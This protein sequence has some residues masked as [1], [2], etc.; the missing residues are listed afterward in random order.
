MTEEFTFTGKGVPALK[1][2][3]ETTEKEDIKQEP[4]QKFVVMADT[5]VQVQSG[6]ADT[7]ATQAVVSDESLWTPVVEELNA[8]GENNG[9]AERS[10][11]IIFLLGFGG[12][13]LALLTPCVWPMI[14][15]T[16]SFFLKRTRIV[17]K[18]YAMH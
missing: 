5:L 13:L 15:M 11:L 4:E 3:P 14:P 8:F 9:T 17:K 6:I 12:G 2:K 7:V 10:L 18:Q 1:V 16:V